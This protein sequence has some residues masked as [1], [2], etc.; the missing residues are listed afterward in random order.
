MGEYRFTV[1]IAAPP[2]HVF[3]LWIDLDRMPEWVGG[4]TGVSDATGP[5]DRVGTTY[6]VHFGRMSSRTEVLEV[7]RPRRFRGKFGNRIL[8]GENEAMFESDGRGGTVLRQTLRT[9]GVVAAVAARIFATGSF[10]GSFRGEL[11]EF[12]RLAEREERSRRDSLETELGPGVTS[13]TT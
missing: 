13:G 12:G 5:L 3:D 10:R 6:T 2:E 7:E 4:V 1:H 11:A 9:N 8:R